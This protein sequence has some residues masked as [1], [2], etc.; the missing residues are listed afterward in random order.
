MTVVIGATGANRFSEAK[1][2][3]ISD[4]KYYIILSPYVTLAMFHL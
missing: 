2:Y 1:Y 3:E 4:V